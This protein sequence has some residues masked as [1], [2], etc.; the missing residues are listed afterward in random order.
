[1]KC[2]LC[3]SSDRAE[4]PSEIALHFPGLINWNKPHVFIFPTALVCLDCGF[5]QCEIPENQLRELKEG[6]ASSA[7]A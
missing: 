1:M 5:L 2:A 6:R 3:G 7:A 4:F